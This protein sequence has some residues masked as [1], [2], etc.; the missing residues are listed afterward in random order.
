MKKLSFVFVVLALFIL[1]CGNGQ[2]ETVMNGN[3]ESVQSKNFSSTPGVIDIKENMFITMINDINLNSKDYFGKT[4][5]IEGI[6]KRSV[7]EGDYSYYVIR[8]APG[9][10][11]D[12]GEVGFK[13]TLDPSYNGTDNGADKDIYPAKDAWVEAIGE[14]KSYEKLGFTFLYLS[15]T[16]LNVLEKRGL[17]FVSR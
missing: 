6:F 8:R 14:L 15:L 9:C 12:D 5:K 13:V 3:P 11:G 16:E 10:C 17:E 4:I 7:W 2:K 1:S